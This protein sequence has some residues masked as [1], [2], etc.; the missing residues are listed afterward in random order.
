V[1][2]LLAKDPVDR[3]QSVRALGAD[4]DAVMERLECGRGR[5]QLGHLTR[6][7]MREAEEART[8][9]SSPGFQ[10]AQDGDLDEVITSLYPRVR[11]ASSSQELV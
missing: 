1:A 9:R 5:G 11:D 2:R 7:A 4:M 8:S 3:Y 10:S 6:R